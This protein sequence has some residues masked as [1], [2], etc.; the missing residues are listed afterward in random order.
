MK[1]ITYILF[2]LI[3]VFQVVSQENKISLENN[4]RVNFLNPGV[5][6]EFATGEKSV[7]SLGL[8][9]GY[10]GSYRELE[11]QSKD[12]FNYIISP[13][14]DMQ[15]KII[16]NRDKRLNQGKNINNNSGNYISIRAMARG[17]SI[18]ENVFREDNKDIVIG[19]TW[20][21]QRSFKKVHFLFDIGPQYY[22]DSIGNNG[23]FPL[24]LQLNLGLN[25]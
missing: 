10:S 12:G 15:Y 11:V 21:I 1:T 14:L 9:V 6:Y 24:M 13:F 22:F 8:G 16:Y 20:G 5:E 25:L 7:I 4:W 23:F 19:P 17:W 3:F 2:I 18:A